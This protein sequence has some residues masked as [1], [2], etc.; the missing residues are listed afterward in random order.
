MSYFAL[1]TREH[2]EV[3]GMGGSRVENQGKLMSMD[4]EDVKTRTIAL[5]LLIFG[6]QFGAYLQS[7]TGRSCL[8]FR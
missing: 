6:W 7:Q 8:D 3:N 4:G 2:R 1:R 5:F